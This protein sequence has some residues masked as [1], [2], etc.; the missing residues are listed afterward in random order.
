[1]YNI[2]QIR[3]E[4]DELYLNMYEINNFTLNSNITTPNKKLSEYLFNLRKQLI[5]ISLELD[6]IEF[7][8]NIEYKEEHNKLDKIKSN[9]SLFSDY[10]D[11]I[12]QHKN[13]DSLN[14]IQLINFIFLPLGFIV[15]FFG[16]NFDAMGVYPSKN[17]IFKIK[18]VYAFLIFLFIVSS[19]LMSILYQLYTTNS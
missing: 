2:I 15:G 1:M 5:K 7:Q 18:N 11:L 6:K 10:N 12:L 4:I 8:S 3:E 13:K 17:G 14:M 16:M 9:L 19:M